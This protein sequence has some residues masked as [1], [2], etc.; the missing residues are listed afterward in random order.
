MRLALVVCNLYF[1]VC[2]CLENVATTIATNTTIDPC[3]IKKDSNWWGDNFCD[4][5]MNT[6]ECEYDGGD[7]CQTSAVDGWDTWCDVSVRIFLY[8]ANILTVIQA[9]VKALVQAVVQAMV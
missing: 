5:Y 9:L 2:A 3:P 8:T 7:C 4:D 6:V 1:Q